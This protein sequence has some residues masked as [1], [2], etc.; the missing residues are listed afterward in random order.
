MQKASSKRGREEIAVKLKMMIATMMVLLLF[1]QAGQGFTSSDP[2]GDLSPWQGNIWS[3]SGERGLAGGLE[4]SIANDFCDRLTSQFRDDPKPSCSDLERS[5][6]SAFS[7]W[8]RGNPHIRFVDVSS[9]VTAEVAPDERNG[10]WFG[11]EINIFALSRAEYDRLRHSAVTR[12]YGTTRD[13]V[14]TSRAQKSGWVTILGSEIVFATDRCYY[15]DPEITA[16]SCSYFPALFLHEAGHALGL[17][18]PQDYRGRNIVSASGNP[19]ERVEVS[20][21]NPR[22]GFKESRNIDRNAVM[23]ATSLSKP[24]N[25]ELQ[26]DDLNGR[27]YLY[28]PCGNSSASQPPEDEDDDESPFGDIA[29]LQVALQGDG[30]VV[31]SPEGVNCPTACTALFLEGQ[32][33]KLTANPAEGASFVEWLGACEGSE[34]V[35]TLEMPANDAS[36]TARFSQSDDGAAHAATPEAQRPE[37]PR[38][39]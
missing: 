23:A 19:R 22:Q 3:A 16:P 30:T 25:N 1:S 12:R 38:M 34:P 31:S 4:Y 17:T 15:L 36:V 33:I 11:A 29:T 32:E 10:R 5:I 7:K 35:C 20:C 28:P 27:D 9:Q 6:K 18:H 37:P 2:T 14:G 26:P 39:Y 21:H 13:P 8:A 24:E